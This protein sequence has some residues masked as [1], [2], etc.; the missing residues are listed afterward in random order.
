MS[1]MLKD[2]HAVLDYAVDWGAE[3]LSADTLVDSNWSVVPTEPDGLFVAASN[4]DEKVARVQVAGGTAGRLYR[5][6]NTVATVSG[7]EDSRSLM[8]RVERR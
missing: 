4:F 1:L 6:V 3:Y 5:L 7:R 8:L 2:P